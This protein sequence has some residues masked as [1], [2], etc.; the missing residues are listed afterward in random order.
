VHVDVWTMF[1]IC[2]IIGRPTQTR[3]TFK[4]SSKVTVGTGYVSP[5]PAR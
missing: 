5:G 1:G 3:L 2:T 4:E